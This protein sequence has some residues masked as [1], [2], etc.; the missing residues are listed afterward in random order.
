MIT[1]MLILL[2]YI[3]AS[4]YVA[5]VALIKPF[6]LHDDAQVVLHNKPNDNF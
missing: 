2:L 5:E 4:H 6:G 3:A 1:V